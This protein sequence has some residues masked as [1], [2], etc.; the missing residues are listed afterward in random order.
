M[1][2]ANELLAVARRELGNME[3]PANSNRTKYGRWFGLD[4]YAWCMMF[5]Q[6]VFDQA[7]VALPRRTAS[8]GE[9]MRAAQAAG[10]WVTR[11]FLPG[12]VVIY[13]FP[14]GAATDHCGIVE[15]ELPDYGVQ[16]IEGNTSQSG[17][18]SN[19]GMVCRKSR[20]RKYIVGAIR[21]QFE[22]EDDM[23]ISAVISQITDK[24]AYELMVKAQRY[25]ASLPEPAWSQTE[26]HWQRA[27]GTGVINGGSPEGLLKRD[28]FVAV[29]GRRGLL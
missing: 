17:S 27:A 6:W 22:K 21:P 28:E 13:D 29:M 5:V 3:S 7:G 14:G 20:P 10:C 26:G 19:G 23:D 16:A 1:A 9:L 25:A 8:C 4:G 12:D 2:G 11:D 24:Q 15:M 18:Q